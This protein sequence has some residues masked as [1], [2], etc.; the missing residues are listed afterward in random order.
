MFAFIHSLLANVTLASAL[1]DL[2]AL[3]ES[4]LTSATLIS[5]PF[6]CSVFRATANG[7]AFAQTPGNTKANVLSVFLSFGLN[8][9]G[10]H[11]G[12]I[13]CLVLKTEI[14]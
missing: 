9:L 2:F 7:H 8:L 10:C 4:L 1:V 3:I 5:A 13:G 14:E 12:V 6:A 11:D